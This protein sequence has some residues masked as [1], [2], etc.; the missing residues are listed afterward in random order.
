MRPETR[1]R[2]TSAIATLGYIPNSAARQLKTGH[3]PMLGLLLPNVVNPYFGELT[4]AIDFA[5]QQYD[6]RTVLC[7]TQRNPDRELAFVRELV[8]DG[9]RG[10]VA[11]SVFKNTEA[12][13]RLIDQGVAFVLLETLDEDLGIE[14]VDVVTMDNTLA[15][16]KAIDYLAEQG[17][18]AIAYV[19]AT[20]LTPH[21]MARMDGFKSAM[22][23]HGLNAQCIITD[24]I[25]PSRATSHNDEDFAHFG[26]MAAQQLLDSPVKPSAVLV[27]NDIIAFGLLSG[28]HEQGIRVPEDI[29]V[30]GIDGIQLT[31]FTSPPLTTLN[32]PYQQIASAAIDCIRSRLADPKLPGRKIILEPLLTPRGSTQLPA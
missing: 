20:P 5:A 6:Y 7:N 29:A 1:E 28:L 17:H 26:R 30:I 10:I 13:K 32:Q 4:V 16:V 27:M 23:R 11:A 12:M 24:E 31:R 15:S 9:V 21:R 19:T 22:Q 25:M 18:T 14:H 8:A 2:I 3:S